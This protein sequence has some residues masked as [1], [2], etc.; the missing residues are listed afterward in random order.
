PAQSSP[1]LADCRVAT[2]SI[3]VLAFRGSSP[4]QDPSKD[5]SASFTGVQTKSDQV[6]H[7]IERRQLTPPLPLATTSSENRL[8][9]FLRKELT[10][11]TDAHTNRTHT[12]LA[13]QSDTSSLS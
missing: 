5:R 11:R 7:Q 3:E 12:H 4:H 9:L 6:V 1:A 8:D 10:Q 2:K 13:L